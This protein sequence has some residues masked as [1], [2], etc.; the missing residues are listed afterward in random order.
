[1]HAGNRA[2]VTGANGHV[3]NNLVKALL[4]RGWR[5][6]A[7]VRDATDSSRTR[8]LPVRD[9]EVVGLDVRDLPQFEQVSQGVDVLFHVAATYKN[10]TRT[11]AEAEEM[12]R[13]A[14]E[15]ACNAVLAAAKNRISRL[16]LTSSVVTIPLVPRGGRATTEEDWR[17]DFTL[18]YHRAKTLAEKEA[19][20]L[21][22][23]HDVNMVAVL[24]GGILG[25]GFARGTSSTDVIESIWRGGLKNGAPNANFPAVDI[26]DVVQGHILA[27]EKADA[28]GRFILI[29]DHLPTLS[30]LARAAHEA[31]PAVPP[32]GKLLP[33]FVMS[34]APF[35]DWV[36]HKTTG[37][38]R[39]VSAEFVA[40]VAGKEWTMSNARARKDLG[41]SQTVPLQQSVADTLA[42]LKSLHR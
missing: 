8:L 6:R 42:T 13:D 22:R 32:A 18:P 33:D 28:S 15:G 26:R 34:F 10:Y 5:V 31:D 1:M 9:V 11:K 17:T 19:W 12:T 16:V 36:T 40:A 14:V 39:T 2:L 4:A 7:S 41:W 24:P 21:A 37:A 29:N 35:F 3:G 30:E 20:R 25:P 38:P 27:A 23:E